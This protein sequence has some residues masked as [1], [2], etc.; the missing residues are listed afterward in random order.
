V[1]IIINRQQFI[2]NPCPA[3]TKSV[4]DYFYANL[5]RIYR[6]SEYNIHEKI[7][8]INIRINQAYEG[9]GVLHFYVSMNGCEEF[10]M[11]VYMSQPKDRF[12]RKSYRYDWIINFENADIDMGKNGS[13]RRYKERWERI[14][15]QKK[16]KEA[17][18]KTK[19]RLELYRSLHKEFGLSYVQ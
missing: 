5:W 12:D 14:T 19:N 2:N 18:L 8:T 16:S 1:K 4:M 10:H 9:F 13:S 15:L 3:L 11:E 6:N 7:E 17:I